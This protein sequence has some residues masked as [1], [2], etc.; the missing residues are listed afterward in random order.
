MAGTYMG[1]CVE[2]DHVKNLGGGKY[3][4]R[5]PYP[6]SLEAD[7]G[8]QLRETAICRTD[9]MLLLGSAAL[10]ATTAGEAVGTFY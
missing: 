7:L 2:L 4:F 6:P 8:Q 1:I 5:E 3:Q 10:K 9:V